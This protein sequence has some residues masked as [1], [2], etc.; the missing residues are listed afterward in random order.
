MTGG[1]RMDGDVAVYTDDMRQ[2]H[3][4]RILLDDQ[5]DVYLSILPEGHKI[6]PTVRLCASGGADNVPG[7]LT[8]LCPFVEGSGG[9]R[10]LNYDDCPLH[11][12][13]SEHAESDVGR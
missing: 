3:E 13:A 2:G 5:G 11:G 1:A 8:A 7:L 9:D 6:G 12:R 4:L 10:D